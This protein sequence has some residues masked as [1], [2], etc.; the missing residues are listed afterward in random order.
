MHSL[1]LE[2][3]TAVKWFS[4]NKTIVN[5]E[6]FK[7]IVISKNKSDYIA[8]VFSI[9]S[10]SVNIEQSIKLLGIHLDNQ[11][12]FNLHIKKIC[13]SASHPLNT[14]VRRKEFLDLVKKR[15]D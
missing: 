5:P 9:G 7:A 1:K 10:D 8:S 13:K 14:L 3:E 15:F 4:A 12:N 6:K 2:F 11:L